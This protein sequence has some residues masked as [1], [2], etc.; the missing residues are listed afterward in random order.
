MQTKIQF[1]NK[2]TENWLFNKDIGK[3][4]NKNKEIKSKHDNKL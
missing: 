2:K 3:D 4:I 1:V